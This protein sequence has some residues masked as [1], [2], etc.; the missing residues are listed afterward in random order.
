M[1]LTGQ[2]KDGEVILIVFL[3]KKKRIAD[4]CTQS[5]IRI[6]SEYCYSN[7]STH[8]FAPFGEFFNIQFTKKS[9]ERSF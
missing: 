9:Q 4:Q 5:T 2:R 3:E 6:L 1:V 7:T 8:I